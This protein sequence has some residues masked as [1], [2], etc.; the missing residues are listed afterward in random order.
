MS[1]FNSKPVTTGSLL[2]ESEDT[3]SIFR[4]TLEKLTSISERAKEQSAMKLEEAKRAEKE[5]VQYKLIADDNLNVV[6]NFNKLLNKE[7]DAN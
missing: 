5:A 3:L 6:E 4:K 7:K 2:K 1:L